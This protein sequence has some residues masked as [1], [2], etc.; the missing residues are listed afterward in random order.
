MASVDNVFI[1]V[2]QR[3]YLFFRFL[4]LKSTVVLGGCLGLVAA[5]LLTVFLFPATV[6]LLSAGLLIPG[7]VGL[8]IGIE[9]AIVLNLLLRD[10]KS[11]DRNMRRLLMWFAI[12]LA[13]FFITA[14]FLTLALGVAPGLLFVSGPGA[15]VALGVLGAAIGL[16]ALAGVFALARTAGTGT[17]GAR[18]W[19][20]FKEVLMSFYKGPEFD[21]QSDKCFEVAESQISER[22]ASVSIVSSEESDG[23]LQELQLQVETSKIL[24]VM[25][26]GAQSSGKTQLLCKLTDDFSRY[27]GS[28]IA[29][30]FYRKE[31]G[32]LPPLQIWD[33]AGNIGFRS[34]IE[35]YYKDANAI[36][37]AYD[38]NDKTSL[39]ALHA[40]LPKLVKE[41]PA[42]TP[43]MLVACKNDAQPQPGKERVTPEDIR[44]FIKDAEANHYG[45]SL[46]NF[47]T[48]TSSVTGE[49]VDDAFEELARQALGIKLEHGSA[50]A[51]R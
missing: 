41:L 51:P 2:D 29:L 49:G 36:M 7:A 47:E 14:L 4:G 20:E 40:F 11:M 22:R 44:L 9:V 21:L 27:D 19:Q 34:I 50:S 28:T 3:G 5:T 1:K 43:M 10:E 12:L 37:L 42:A 15:W 26:I 17:R 30:D 45:I 33:T 6:L 38:I 48:P 16:L 25:I 8:L 24:K 32:D 35:S 13:P 46:E 18:V 31:I 39:E 23:V